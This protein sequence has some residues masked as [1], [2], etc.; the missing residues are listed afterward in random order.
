MTSPEMASMLGDAIA[1]QMADQEK[2]EA[3]FREH[4]EQLND[5]CEAI[6]QQIV[7]AYMKKRNAAEPQYPP[8]VIEIANALIA[9]PRL[10]R[11]VQMFLQRLIAEINQAVD[12][13]VAEVLGAGSS[14]TESSS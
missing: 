12:E 7:E 6:Q 5:Q 9:Q 14:E 1:S 11:P 8:Q 10:V 4:Q 2:T 3:K 13:A